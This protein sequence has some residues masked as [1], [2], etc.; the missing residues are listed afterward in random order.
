MQMRDRRFEGID[1]RLRWAGTHI[2]VLQ[3]CDGSQRGQAAIGDRQALQIE[4]L[5]R[6]QPGKM[7]KTRIRHFGPGETK[8]LQVGQLRQMGDAGVADRRSLEAQEFQ[9]VQLFDGRDV[10]IASFDTSQNQR[11]G[12]PVGV[13]R[14][15]AAQMLQGDNRIEFGLGGRSLATPSEDQSQKRR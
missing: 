1:A 3:A 11:H 15:L 6:R 2:D 8:R 13:G 12:V 7:H 5:Q 10:G 9:V 14:D 4:I